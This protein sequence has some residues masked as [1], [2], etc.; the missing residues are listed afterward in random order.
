MPGRCITRFSHLQE[1]EIILGLQ[2][3]EAIRLRDIVRRTLDV[4]DAVSPESEEFGTLSHRRRHFLRA[5]LDAEL[6]TDVPGIFTLSRNRTLMLSG[7]GRLK[8]TKRKCARTFSTALR[9]MDEFPEFSFSQSQALLYEYTK[10]NYPDIYRQIKR[11]VKEG[12]W[13]PIGAMWVEPDCNIPNGESLVRQIL[14]GKKFFKEEFGIDQN[15][16][17]L[18]DTFGYSWALPQILLKSGIKYFFTTKLT[19]NDTNKFPHNA[20]WWEGIDGTKVLAHIPSVG[21][22]GQVTPKHI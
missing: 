9:L 15:I 8:E 2:S 11:R 19:W 12:R 18:P 5:T 7:S 20:F 21:L 10:Q 4:F 14:Y 16:L 13:H 22:E 17:W 1:L 3:N 6:K